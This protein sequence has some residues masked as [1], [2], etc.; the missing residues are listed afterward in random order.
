MFTVFVSGVTVGSSCYCISEYLF[1]SWSLHNPYLT[2]VRANSFSAGK[3]RNKHR[4]NCSALCGATSEN[5]FSPLFFPNDS[6][7]PEK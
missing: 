2:T 4:N 6:H 3:H 7:P 1:F 5:Y